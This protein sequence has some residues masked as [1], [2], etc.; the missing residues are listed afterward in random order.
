MDIKKLAQVSMDGPHV[1][2]KLLDM[3]G[4]DRKLQDQ[5]PDFLNVTLAV[6]MLFMVPF[7]VEC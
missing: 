7:A 1:N 3:L 5:H 4:D 2:W 6:F